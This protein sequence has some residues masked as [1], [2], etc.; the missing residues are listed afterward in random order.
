ME[1]RIIDLE[2]KFAFQEHTIEELQKTVHEQ[3]LAI[4]KL[5]KA[6]KILNDKFEAYSTNENEIGPAN[7]KPPHY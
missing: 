4:Q 7:Q 5:E 3:Y 2:T 6:I 1:D